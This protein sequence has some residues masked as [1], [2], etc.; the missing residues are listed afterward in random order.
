MREND[1]V[2][3]GEQ[4]RVDVRVS[5]DVWMRGW[6]R[7]SG[8]KWGYDRVCPSVPVEDMF[9]GPSPDAGLADNLPADRPVVSPPPDS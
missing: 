3:D 1:R 9:D 6:V 2:R 5:E 7:V 4:R 8:F